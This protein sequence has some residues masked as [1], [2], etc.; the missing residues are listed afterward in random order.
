M[1]HNQ[2][3]LFAITLVKYLDVIYKYLFSVNCP[4]YLKSCFDKSGCF[5]KNSSCNGLYDCA[6]R[7]DEIYCRGGFSPCL[8][9]P[10]NC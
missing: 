6:D 3:H 5:D 10:N 1:I 9:R 7:S 4:D 8:F 2:M